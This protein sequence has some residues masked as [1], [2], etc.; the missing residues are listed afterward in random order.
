LRNYDY[1]SI[2][3]GKKVTTNELL[4][5]RRKKLVE[6]WQQGDKEYLS[7]RLKKFLEIQP[8]SL[9]RSLAL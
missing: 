1:T 3:D 7:I 6:A 2:V 8:N 5:H 4:E 9:M